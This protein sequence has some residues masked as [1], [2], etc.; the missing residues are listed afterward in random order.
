MGENSMMNSCQGRWMGQNPTHEIK[1][2][3]T[4]TKRRKEG[5]WRTSGR[6]FPC[7]LCKV[8]LRRHLP[9]NTIKELMG[10]SSIPWEVKQVGD[11]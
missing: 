9:N 7:H 4:N 6:G 8:T 3:F 1:S 10:D 2:V 5:T 11:T